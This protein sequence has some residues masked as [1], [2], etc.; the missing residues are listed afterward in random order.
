MKS[1]TLTI[2]V[3]DILLE[4]LLSPIVKR[5]VGLSFDEELQII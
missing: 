1:Q 5:C 2:I 3:S 4:I